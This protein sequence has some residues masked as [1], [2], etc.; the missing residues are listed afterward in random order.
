MEEFRND[1]RG[2]LD[3]VAR[4]PAGYVIN[5]Q[6]SLNS[7]D[8]RFHRA[9]CHTVTGTPPRGRAWTGPYVKICSLD[10]GALDEWATRQIGAPIR[11]C[12]TC[13]PPA[14]RSGVAASARPA[15]PFERRRLSQARAAAPPRATMPGL[16]DD[17]RRWEIRGPSNANPVL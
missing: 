7:R 6:R 10:I 2:Y 8:A 12:G 11:R 13:R 4:N 3:W 14:P 5:I 17:D 16:S 15:R 1:D 9:D